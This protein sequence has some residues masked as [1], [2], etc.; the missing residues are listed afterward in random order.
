MSTIGN[1]LNKATGL[2][3]TSSDI[4]PEILLDACIDVDLAIQLEDKETA[5]EVLSRLQKEIQNLQV[6][7]YYLHKF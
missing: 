2:D 5:I 4:D 6:R 1:W 7:V 3:T